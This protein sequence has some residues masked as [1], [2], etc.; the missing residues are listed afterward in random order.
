MNEIT[1]REARSPFAAA[2]RGPV[3]VPRR[4]KPV[5]VMVSPRRYAL[6]RGAAWAQLTATMDRMGA[7][8]AARGLTGRELNRLLARTDQPPRSGR[9]ATPIP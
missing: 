4:G 8:A 7:E 1:A 5:A 3:P 2:Q 6:L 9:A